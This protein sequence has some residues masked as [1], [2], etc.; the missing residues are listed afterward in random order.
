MSSDEQK[1]ANAI[2]LALDALKVADSHIR[3]HA[4]RNEETGWISDEFYEAYQVLHS[5][6]RTRWPDSGV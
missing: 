2:E 4:G 6:Y 1:L 5:Y 3:Q